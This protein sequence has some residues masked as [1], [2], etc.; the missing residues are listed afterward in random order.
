M[1][2]VVIQD[3][4]ADVYVHN[5]GLPSF[6]IGAGV[7]AGLF[8]QPLNAVPATVSRQEGVAHVLKT[9]VIYIAHTYILLFLYIHIDVHIYRMIYL[10][11]I[12]CHSI[13]CQSLRLGGP[14][15]EK[16]YVL[17]ITIDWQTQTMYWRHT[18]SMLFGS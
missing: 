9:S 5:N 10:L 2:V 3:S 1:R 17:N 18:R 7:A 12:F 15:I 11:W 14:H 8:Y 4:D 6:S 13:F 16:L